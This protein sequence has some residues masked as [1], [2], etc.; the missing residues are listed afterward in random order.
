MELYKVI[1]K[2]QILNENSKDNI[3]ALLSRLLNITKPELLYNG[4]VYTLKSNLELLNAEKIQ[5]KLNSLGIVTH[6]IEENPVNEVRA[7]EGSESSNSQKNDSE[8][9][10][11]N[12]I[13][14]ALFKTMGFLGLT[15]GIGIVGIGAYW[16]IYSLLQYIFI[17]PENIMQQSISENYFNQSQ[18]GLLIASVGLLI[19]EVKKCR[20]AK[21]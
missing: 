1:F 15:S 3:T 19:M 13:N 12:W 14:K 18:L 11:E 9:N 21:S 20:L 4:T 8:E 2:G 16:F 5:G 7:I 17:T 10:F 6:I